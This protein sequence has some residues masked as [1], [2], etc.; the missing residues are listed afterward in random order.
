MTMNFVVAVSPG[1]ANGY[2]HNIRIGKNYATRNDE[3]IIS[4]RRLADQEEL[5]N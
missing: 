2:N 5:L 1:T 3:R 4:N